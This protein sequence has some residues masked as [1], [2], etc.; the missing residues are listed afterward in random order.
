[1][2]PLFAKMRH[3]KDGHSSGDPSSGMNGMN[4][5]SVASTRHVFRSKG[6]IPGEG[7]KRMPDDQRGRLFTM[8]APVAKADL[9]NVEMMGLPMHGIK[10]Q[11]DLEQ[12]VGRDDSPPSDE[13][14]ERDGKSY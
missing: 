13:W 3:N 5:N 1:M 2:G 14:E 10:V 12:N 4:N 11:T 9:D 7:F 8:A 6:N